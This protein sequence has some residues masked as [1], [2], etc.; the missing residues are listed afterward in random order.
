[1]NLPTKTS[2][3]MFDIIASNLQQVIM[4]D[5][6]KKKGSNSLVWILKLVAKF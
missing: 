5:T 6:T 4:I 1:M 3:F 2:Q